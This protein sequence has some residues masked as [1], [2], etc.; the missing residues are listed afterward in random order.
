[1]ACFYLNLYLCRFELKVCAYNV[2]SN[3]PFVSHDIGPF[4]SGPFVSHD[5]AQHIQHLT[6]CGISYKELHGEKGGGGGAKFMLMVD[7][8]KQSYGLLFN[9]LNAKCI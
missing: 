5:I 3:R 9:S 2:L 1:M 6:F 4:V 8:A 7:A